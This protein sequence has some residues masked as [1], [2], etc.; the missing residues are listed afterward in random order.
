MYDLNPPRVFVHKRVYENPKAVARLER[1][2]KGLKNPPIEE[3][4]ETDTEM[5]VEAA[6]ASDDLPVQSSRV[7][8][9]IEKR[10]Q[11]P[12]FIFNTYVWDPDKIKPMAKK[13]KNPRAS[14]IAHSLAGKGP[15]SIYGRRDHCDG[16]DPKRPY[17]CQGG[18]SI[19]TIN[20][21]AHRCDY[22]QMGYAI[23]FMLD[24]EEFAKE[25]E[26]NF[27]ERPEQKLYRYD[28]TS[29]YPCFEPEYGAS[30]LLG[31]CFAKNDRYLL[32]YTKSNNIDHLLDLPYKE[33]MPCY[34]TVATDTQTQT[35]ERGTPNLDE[36]LE[37]MRKCQEAGYVVRAGF[38]PIVPHK[39]WREEAT[40]A[41]EKLFAA[42]DVDTVRLWV[43]A[44]MLADEAEQIFGAENLDPWCL[45]EMRKHATD[46]DGKHSG[47][48]PRH[49]R[50]EIY[51]HYI[52]EI[53]RIA[54]GT[55]VNLCTEERAMWDMLADHLE[56]SPDNLYCCCGQ[57]SVPKKKS[58]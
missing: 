41:L 24:L 11:D 3:I 46:M 43:V 49:V 32:V 22:C 56:M 35:I 7:R 48:F 36:R 27:K 29:D 2:M 19:H 55:P 10:D 17:V 16:S 44:M 14:M 8:M 37:A 31:E 15:A 13:Y 9:G 39:N 47:P 34:W 42:A 1:M 52:D 6:G 23:N 45:D 58:A 57:K 5:V 28:L 50:A 26:R 40:I 30:E 54:P 21:C 33:H 18:W 38:S 4:D 20:G 12:L 25:L 51:A 53:K